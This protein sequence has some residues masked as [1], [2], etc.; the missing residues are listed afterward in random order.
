MN[1]A[2]RSLQTAIALAMFLAWPVGSGPASS[3]EITHPRGVVELFTSQGCSSC[4][5]ADRVL[6]ELVGRGDMLALGWHVDY[7][8]YLGWKDTF[9]SPANTERQKA[10]ARS[11]GKR[12]VYTPQA[13]INGR[14]DIVGSHEGSVL[15]TVEEFAGTENGLLV[16]I[17]T[18]ISGETIRIRVDN[19]PLARGAKL[20]MVYLDQ[21]KLVDVKRG[22]NGGH[23]LKYSNVVK[24]MEMIGMVKDQ[25]LQTEF[26]LDDVLQRGHDACA[27]ILQKSTESGD[28]GPIIGAAF[29]HDP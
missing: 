29:L 5:A 2:P 22:E 17:E 28:P 3:A 4:P 21:E 23:R 14:A 24:S 1:R 11:L 19:S 18:S 6:T 9:A 25:A 7:W 10:Y 27:L 15:A 16:P 26:A 12:S 13:V 8:D 20:W